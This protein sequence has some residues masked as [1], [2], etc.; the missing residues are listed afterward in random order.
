MLA[1]SYFV[2]FNLL[3]LSST[4]LALKLGLS[5]ANIALSFLSSLLRLDI[6]D[7]IMLVKSVF[8]AGVGGLMILAF[9]TRNQRIKKT[10]LLT[11]ILFGAVF[12]LVSLNN[13]ITI[14]SVNSA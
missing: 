5:E 6:V 14:Y 12:A 11:I 4:I 9:T 7:I 8:F 13:F 10:V 2:I 3:D 1:F